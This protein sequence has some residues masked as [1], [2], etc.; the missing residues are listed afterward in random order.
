MVIYAVHPIM[1]LRTPIEP[2][3]HS[4]FRLNNRW[5]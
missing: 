5:N 1:H 2:S 3:Y 4:L